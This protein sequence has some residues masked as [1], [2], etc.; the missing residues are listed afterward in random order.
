MLRGPPHLVDASSHGRFSSWGEHEKE[1]SRESLT[2]WRGFIS[3]HRRSLTQLGLVGKKKQKKQDAIHAS[4]VPMLETTTTPPHQ[5]PLARWR[6]QA[7][8][9]RLG[10][11]QGAGMGAGYVPF[12]HEPKNTT[13]VWRCTGHMQLF[14][15]QLRSHAAA[16][17]AQFCHCHCAFLAPA[18]GARPAQPTQPAQQISHFSLFHSPPA[19][20][21]S[22]APPGTNSPVCRVLCRLLS[23]VNYRAPAVARLHRAGDA[24]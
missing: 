21:A 13:V 12:S 10:L 6:I 3:T 5:N 19:L 2:V 23:L 8:F 9:S 16:G 7:G 15:V 22:A 4:E 17:P 24:S 1:C 20:P 14:S 18:P 11:A